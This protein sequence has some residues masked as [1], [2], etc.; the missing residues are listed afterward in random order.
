MA[1]QAH[2]NLHLSKYHIVGNHMSRL[3]YEWLVHFNFLGPG[4]RLPAPA[5]WIA[6][7]SYEVKLYENGTGR[8]LDVAFSR[9][10][11]VYNFRRFQ[12][13]L[14]PEEDYID[15]QI[16]VTMTVSERVSDIGGSNCCPI[17]C[18]LSQHVPRR[19]RCAFAPPKT[20][21]TLYGLHT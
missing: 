21:Q 4:G 2:L 11:P 19:L 14:V 7:I 16:G 17:C 12:V 8:M 5:D 15:T 1:A 6:T 20:R 10:P 9:P 3:K 13:A 18:Y